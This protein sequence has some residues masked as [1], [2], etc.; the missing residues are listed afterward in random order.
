[1]RSDPSKF[2]AGPETSIEAWT[3]TA[4]TPPPLMA[5][6]FM[7]EDATLLAALGAV[8]IRHAQLEHALRLTV[9]TLLGK[10]VDEIILWKPRAGPAKLREEIMKHAEPILR[11]GPVL[12]ELG[13]LL[14]QIE[15][16]TE[17]RNTVMHGVWIHDEHRGA[18]LYRHGEMLPLPSA[19]ELTELCETMHRN[20]VNLNESRLVGPLG[21]AIRAARER[22]SA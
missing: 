3:A 14:D 10:T 15:S 9:R 7:P 17:R 21:E 6:P 11:P 19:Q 12:A 22:D 5:R 20:S 18:S 1:M 4:T 8:A 16:L 13:S 2:T